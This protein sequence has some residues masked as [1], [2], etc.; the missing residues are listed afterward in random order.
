MRFCIGLVSCHRQPPDADR[1]WRKCS[2]LLGKS[3]GS[4]SNMLQRSDISRPV[5]I[6]SAL[7]IAAIGASGLFLTVMAYAAP[8]SELGF[9]AEIARH[10]HTMLEEGKKTFRYETFGSE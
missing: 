2:S 9:D 7:I 5:V 8:P 1:S 10:A 6:S 3:F 4:R